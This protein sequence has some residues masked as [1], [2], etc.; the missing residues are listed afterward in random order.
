MEKQT[1]GSGFMIETALRYLQLGYRPIPIVAGTKRAA[2][3]W[4][5]WQTESPTERDIAKWFFAG[6]RNIALVTGT[7][8]V[9]VD[10][11]DP[12]LLDTVIERCGDTPMRCRT[13][14]GDN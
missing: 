8:V 7:G 12:E 6:E 10:V 2:I 13:T 1:N 9:V 5:V 4:K 14:T 3:K 11:D